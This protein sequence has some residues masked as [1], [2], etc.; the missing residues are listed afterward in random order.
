M[1]NITLVIKSL[2]YFE[3]ADNDLEPKCFFDYSWDKIKS[4]IKKEASKL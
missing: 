2:F 3:D 1:I 4:K